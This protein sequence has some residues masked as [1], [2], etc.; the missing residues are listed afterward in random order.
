M[1]FIQ[2]FTFQFWR[3]FNSPFEFLNF[4]IVATYLQLKTL[5][6]YHMQIL[7]K[8]AHGKFIYIYNIFIVHSDHIEFIIIFIL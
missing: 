2:T 5:K 4:L 1:I 8:L 6:I 3:P 7:Q